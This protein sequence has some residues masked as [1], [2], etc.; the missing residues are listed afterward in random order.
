M[1]LFLNRDLKI[2]FISG[3]ILHTIMVLTRMEFSFPPKC[4]GGDCAI[5]YYWDIPLSILY[6]A[7]DD[8]RVIFASLL[9]GAI[10]WGFIFWGL[11]LGLKIILQK[12][13]INR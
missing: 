11:L 8:S 9:L 5:I 3:A 13:G 6:Y 10:Y 12:K 2:G 4:S 7:F 1:N